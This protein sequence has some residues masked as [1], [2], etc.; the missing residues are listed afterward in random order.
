MECLWPWKEPLD[1]CPG[2]GIPYQ[3]G[4]FA[5]IPFSWQTWWSCAWLKTKICVSTNYS[6]CNVSW[7]SSDAGICVLF[8][9]RASLMELIQKGFVHRG[10]D[11]LLISKLHLL[12][13]T[14]T[15][16]GAPLCVCLLPYCMGNMLIHSLSGKSSTASYVKHLYYFPD[17]HTPI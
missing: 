13:C 3:R 6:R 15:D 1:S 7:Q 10:G 11:S 17:S 8:S 2:P 14:V 4:V 9:V 16:L 12:F 5:C